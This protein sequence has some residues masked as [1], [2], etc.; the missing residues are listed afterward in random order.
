MRKVRN[1]F[2]DAMEVDRLFKDRFGLSLNTRDKDMWEMFV[3]FMFCRIL[4]K[5]ALCSESH[6]M[7]K[8]G[9]E[10]ECCL[11]LPWSQVT[12]SQS[13]TNLTY[14]DE[15]QPVNR[16]VNVDNF[17]LER[18][19]DHPFMDNRYPWESTEYFLDY[20]FRKSKNLMTSKEL[21]QF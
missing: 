4:S 17:D 16:M 8:S 21:D 11:P 7:T 6:S 9:D 19:F 5:T 1:I 3:E 18:F 10:E 20:L 2:P 13:S 14:L 15:S 12:V